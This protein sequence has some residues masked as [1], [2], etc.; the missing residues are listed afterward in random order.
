MDVAVNPLVDPN[1]QWD[2]AIVGTGMGGSTLGYALAKAGL[3]VLFLEKGPGVAPGP[4][5]SDAVTPRER[6]DRGWWPHPVSQRL[7]DGRVERFFV[8]VGCAVGGSTI[9]YAAALERMEPS[10]FEPLQTPSR[11]LPA[12]PVAYREFLPF[13]EA[14]EALYGLGAYA[15]GSG[16]ELLSE[17]DKALLAAMRQNGLEPARLRVAMRY[18]EDCR[19]C[20]GTVCPR[21]C[22]ADA[23]VACLE[24]A[25]S[26]PGCR[27]LTDCEVQ[28]LEADARRI[29]RI[30][31][32][33]RGEH[34]EVSAR[35]VVLAAGAFHSPQV[36]LRSRNSFWQ[37]GLA[38]HSDQVGRNLMFHTSDLYALWAPRRFNRKGRQRKSISIRDFYVADGRRLGYVQSMGLD[39]GRGN[40]AAFLKDTLRRRGLRHERLLSL[41]VLLPSHVAAWMLGDASIF[42]AMTEDDPDPDNRIV[43]DPQEPD[44]ASFTY[45]VTDDLRRRADSLCEAFAK[46]IRPWRLMRLSPKLTMNYGHPCGTCRFG[47]DPATSVLNR[48]NRAHDVENLYIVD[49]SFM[50]RSGAVNPSLTIAANALRSA[51]PI[52]SSLGV[53][54]HPVTT[55]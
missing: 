49:S 21:Q 41:A 15:K 24:H 5:H 43:L 27:L 25:L 10:D 1:K 8:A 37:N 33:H 19:E 20:I 13:Y 11:A 7:P 36:L 46:K 39:A 44:G 28:T 14:A 40:I 32:V 34:I 51:A 12:W 48:D 35:I 16:E 31:A 22:K 18:D 2:V 6:M 42:A 3:S 29:R 47:D 45:N 9:H 54:R 30:H 26:Q 55:P 52:T 53:G 50:P 38:N 23:R 4:S 17:W